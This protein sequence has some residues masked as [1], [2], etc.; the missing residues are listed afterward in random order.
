LS[1]AAHAV[2][3]GHLGAA[4]GYNMLFPFF[5]AAIAFAWLGWMRVTLGYPAGVRWL[6]KLPT[7]TPV[8]AAVVLVVFAILRNL[9]GLSVLAP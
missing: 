3:R 1:R 5:F 6:P 9:P 8:A 2:L 7:W 4:F